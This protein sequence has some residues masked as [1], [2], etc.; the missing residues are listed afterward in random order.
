[1]HGRRWREISHREEGRK[2][3]ARGL[4]KSGVRSYPSGFQPS[5][6]WRVPEEAE[7]QLRD[8]LVSARRHVTLLTD[9]GRTRMAA[10]G[11]GRHSQLLYFVL[12]AR[13]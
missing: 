3:L 11:W 10:R 1:M 6:S 5:P 8:M 9:S 4:R 7:S 2:R 12:E 13:L